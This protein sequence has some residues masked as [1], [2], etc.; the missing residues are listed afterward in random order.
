MFFCLNLG[1]QAQYFPKIL[2][3]TLVS[4]GDCEGLTIRHQS[5]HCPLNSIPNWSAALISMLIF[6][7][8]TFIA[9]R[10]LYLLCDL[11]TINSM[12]AEMFT[13]LF[14]IYYGDLFLSE[15]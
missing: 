13:G 2:W 7:F 12:E 6:A 14:L 4:V 9:L 3:V 10:I 8:Q 5:H 1:T 15:L 11:L